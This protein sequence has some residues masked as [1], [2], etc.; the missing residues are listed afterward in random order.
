MPLPSVAVIGPGKI[1]RDLLIKLLRSELLQV[2]AL[3]GR[4]YGTSSEEFARALNVPFYGAG[5]DEFLKDLGEI[6][7]VIDATTAEFHPIHLSKLKSYNPYVVDLTPSGIGAI[8]SPLACPNLPLRG[9]SASLVSCGGQTSLPMLSQLESCFYNLEYIEVVSSMASLAVGPGTRKN[10][11]EYI[12]TTQNAIKK[13]I[14][15]EKVKVC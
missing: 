14:N 3:I 9:C 15:V 1:G 7:I 11:D 13:M 4:N 6:S 12:L 8:Y 2:S 5:L 10:I